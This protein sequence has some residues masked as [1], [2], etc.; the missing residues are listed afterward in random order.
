MKYC[1]VLLIFCIACQPSVKQSENTVKNVD[2]VFF[3]F[4]RAK[5]I[6]W[7]QQP[8]SGLS[9]TVIIKFINDTV[10]KYYLGNTDYCWN[11]DYQWDISYDS[12]RIDG[13]I[14]KLKANLIPSKNNPNKYEVAVLNGSF[15]KLKYKL[16]RN[17]FTQDMVFETRDEH[18]IPTWYYPISKFKH[19]P[20][21]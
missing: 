21:K 8:M 15:E 12:Y 19:D 9:K 11:I 16:Y 6:C 5:N 4:E 17:P 10:V 1:F 18:N 13:N 7:M 2:T 20:P 14:L 3:N